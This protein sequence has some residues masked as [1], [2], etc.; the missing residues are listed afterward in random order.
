MIRQGWRGRIG[1]ILVCALLAGCQ[2]DAP[3]DT[4]LSAPL[5]DTAATRNSVGAEPLPRGGPPH[6]PVLAA[7]HHQIS[8]RLPDS[9]QSPETLPQPPEAISV[10][11]AIELSDVILAVQQSYPLLLVALRERRTAEGQR[12]TARGEFDLD[13]KAFG[14][15]APEGFCRTYRNGIALDQPL[16][17]GG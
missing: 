5:A 13:L 14:I 11:D 2:A 17:C 1:T 3:V 10:S 6:A 9:A 12:I 7:S 8:D 15:A 16:Y 4:R